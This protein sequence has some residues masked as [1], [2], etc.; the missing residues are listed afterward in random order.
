MV[1][2]LCIR[3]EYSRADCLLLLTGTVAAIII[4][5]ALC[6]HSQV[7]FTLYA[8]VLIGADRVKSFIVRRS[9]VKQ[10]QIHKYKLCIT[11][12]QI[13][14]Y[15]LYNTQTQIHNPHCMQGLIGA[16]RVKSGSV[17]VRGS[18]VKQ[19][20]KQLPRKHQGFRFQIQIQI[21]IHI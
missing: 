13:H 12:T 6:F 21:Q 9:D 8:R 16:D 19:A 15:K 2:A 18:D 17:I 20:R 4:L 5:Y 14:K 11:Q 3:T 7:Q 1:S 10:T